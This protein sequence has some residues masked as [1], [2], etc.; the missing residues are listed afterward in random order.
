MARRI[1]RRKKVSHSARTRAQE[2]VKPDLKL[3]EAK[4]ISATRVLIAAP[5][6]MRTVLTSKI[7]GSTEVQLAGVAENEMTAVEKVL[8]EEADVAAVYVH[9]DE[10]LGGLEIARNLSKACPQAGILVMVNDLAGIDVRRHARMFG[11]AWSYAVAENVTEGARF[12]ELVQSVGRGIH[13]IDPELRRVLE[14]IWQ[15]AS[16]GA[17]LEAATAA[18]KMAIPQMPEAPTVPEP[19]PRGVQ[20]MQAGKGGVG[21]SGFGV[22]P[23]GDEIELESDEEDDYEEDEAPRKPGG[24]QTMRTGKG[25]I[26]SDG[27]GVSRAG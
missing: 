18:Q 16:E 23:T 24:I 4:P 27:F 1:R 8:T 12:V 22:R 5:G 13:W 9:L 2:P 10:E 17:D 3:P 20:T 15:I 25:G 14:A 6:P 21:S 11:V 7:S 19:K 26:G